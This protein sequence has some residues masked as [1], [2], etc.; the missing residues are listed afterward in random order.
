WEESTLR[1]LLEAR[2]GQDSRDLRLERVLRIY[3]ALVVA[4]GVLG[5][6]GWWW[7]GAGVER[8][9]QIM[10]SIF[11]VS[12]PCAL[13]VAV[14]LAEELAALR[15]QRLGVF[16]RTLGFW[17]K[18]GQIRQVVFDK[19]GTLTLENP[20]LKNPEAIQSLPGQA[21][22]ALRR[23]VEGNLHPVSRSLYDQVGPGDRLDGEVSEK[24]GQG[25]SLRTPENHVWTLGRPADPESADAELRLDGDFVAGFAFT[26]SLRPETATEF[27]ELKRRGIVLRLLSGDRHEKVEKIAQVLGLSADDW[28]AALTPAAKAEWVADH[29]GAT[30]LYIGDGANDSLAF[31]EAC[32]AGS[33][34]TG[35]SFLE[36]KA[37]FFFLGHNLRFVSLLMDVARTHRRAVHGVFFLSTSYNLIT[38]VAGLA[39]MLSPL[40]AAVLMPLSS[41]AT[42]SLVGWTFRADRVRAV[43]HE[44]KGGPVAGGLEVVLPAQ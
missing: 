10:I 8:S 17:K 15:A 18:L 11:V 40:G 7:A 22:A 42:L 34:I 32:C 21:R 41:V 28:Q 6:L 39:G 31:D 13:G 4:A 16:V 29:S 23:M 30:T 24:V 43:G 36:Q 44:A 5:A 1:K 19:T 33:P 25:L 27:A 12:C 14:P 37:D 3:L 35:R 20:A 38:V 2:R 9:L 26:D